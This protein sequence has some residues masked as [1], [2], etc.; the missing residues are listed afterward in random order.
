MRRLSYLARSLTDNRIRS[1]DDTINTLSEG[2]KWTW[3]CRILDHINNYKLDTCSATEPKVGDLV[4]VRVEKIGNHEKIVTINNKRLRIYVGDLLVGVFGNRYATDAFEGE[5]NGL[6]HL[7]I[8]TAAGMIGTVKSKYKEIGEPTRVSSIGF[9][10][11][12][13]GHRINLKEL[14]FYKSLPKSQIKNLIVVVGTR[15]NSGKT[16]SAIKLIKGFSEK[17]LKIAAC[18]LTGSV[19]NRDQ[20]EMRSAA[21]KFIIDFSDYGFPSTYLCTK[22]ELIDLFNTMLSD[23]EK[24]NP[25]V[26]IMEMADGILQRETAMLLKDPS[27]KRMIKG[28]VLTAESTSSALYGVEKLKKLNYNVIAVS[29]VITSSPL[30][31]REFKEHSEIQVGSSIGSGK[32]LVDIV[33]SFIDVER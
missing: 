13:K 22:E 24:I 19:S 20:D 28:I 15:M 8:L 5:V 25:D 6:Q 12:E 16:M 14:K 9:L 33:S 3:A 18:K 17:G 32:E 10:N 4:L 31:V 26:I 30:S 2:I 7:S 29:G 11:D 27:I 23:M 21:A 1:F